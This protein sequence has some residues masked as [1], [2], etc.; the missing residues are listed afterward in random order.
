LL[1]KHDLVHGKTGR[2]ATQRLWKPMPRMRSI[3]R[4]DTD[5]SYDDVPD[6]AGQ[7]IGIET[8]T[9]SDLIALDKKR[10]NKGAHDDWFNPNDPDAKIAKM[11][12]GCRLIWPHK[13]EHAVDLKTGAI[14]GV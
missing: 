11:K 7:G 2:N 9:K 6:Q 14:I 12:D 8:P 3:V 13:A 1:A 5:E 10:K 4:R